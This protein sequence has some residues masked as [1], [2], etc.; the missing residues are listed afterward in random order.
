MSSTKEDLLFLQHAIFGNQIQS[1]DQNM[2]LI[3]YTY[4]S[5]PDKYKNPLNLSTLKQAIL[6]ETQAEFTS[7]FLSDLEV[8][9]LQE[10]E[11]KLLAKQNPKTGKVTFTILDKDTLHQIKQFKEQNKGLPIDY[12][13][14]DNASV[15]DL[16]QLLEPLV[17]TKIKSD[18]KNNKAAQ[19]LFV[20][21]I[22]FGGNLV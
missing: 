11:S 18:L 21:P 14:P 6:D 4:E 8:K 1:D 20:A 16:I 5:I 19:C 17:P 7:I 12:S 2:A 22:Y 15:S 3:K 13:V 10:S 9:S